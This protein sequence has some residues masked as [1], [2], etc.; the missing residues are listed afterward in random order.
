MSCELLEIYSNVLQSLSPDLL[1]QQYLQSIELPKAVEVLAVGKAAVPMACAARKV[2]DDRFVRGFLLTKY[3]HVSAEARELLGES[4]VVREAAH[5]VPDS[6]GRE[7]TLDLLKWLESGSGQLLVLM[8]GGASALLVAPQPPLSLEDLRQV[9]S[10][11]LQSGLPIEKMNVLRK[12]LS[13]VKGGQLAERCRAYQTVKQLVMV[14]ICAPGLQEEEILSLVGSGCFAGDPFTKEQ[15]GE[16]L[17]GL[18]LPYE[19]KARALE[20]LHE[21]PESVVVE[22]AV[23]ASHRTLLEQAQARTGSLLE[24][25]RWPKE[26]TGEVREV[27]R[28]FAEVAR[29]L[30]ETGASGTLVACGEPTVEIRVEKPGRGGRCQEL[31]LLFAREV[32]GMEGVTLLAGS[33]DGTDGPTEDAGA[34]VN[35]RTWDELCQLVGTEAAE[36]C[37]ANHDSGSALARLPGALLRTGPTGQNLNDL[38]LLQLSKTAER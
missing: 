1:V 9:N 13:Q 26:I 18:G 30:K 20:A 37:L 17:D 19:V 6:K 34:L 31:A 29:E 5:P 8:S 36:Q 21:T 14:D 2:L 10:A 32:A 7:A 33:S 25:P 24:H 11:L 23:L 35:G 22:S 16:I 27:A 28:S 12:H 38:Y 3:D 4:F 15:A